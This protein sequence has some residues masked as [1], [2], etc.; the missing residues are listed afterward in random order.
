MADRTLDDLRRQIDDIDDTILD[1]LNRRAAVVIA[2]GK[3][4]AGSHQ[5]FYVPSREQA[6]YRRLT[7]RNPGPFPAE[8]IR[9]VFREIISASLA[10]EQPMKVA[11]LG[12]Q[13]T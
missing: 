11:F 10:L 12:P 13:A 1:L 5:E 9:R 2:V 4:K 6:I 7:E 8:G 3:A